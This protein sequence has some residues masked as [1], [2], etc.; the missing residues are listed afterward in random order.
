V[1]CLKEVDYNSENAD[2][3][4]TYTNLRIHFTEWSF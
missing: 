4:I 3:Y 2:E 1:V